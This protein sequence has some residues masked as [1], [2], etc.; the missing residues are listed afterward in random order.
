MQKFMKK[1]RP[2]F[3]LIEVL[4][5][6]A[7]IVVLT[8]ALILTVKGQV[9]QAHQKDVG[10]MVSTVNAQV[11]VQSTDMESSKLSAINDVKGLLDAGLISTQQYQELQKDHVKVQQSNGRPT[12]STSK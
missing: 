1:R 12:L 4:A 10:L 5:A 3:T 11:E 2:A 8:L 9:E 7:I 6:L